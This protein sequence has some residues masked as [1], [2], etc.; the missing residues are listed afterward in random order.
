[1][2]VPDISQVR[3]YKVQNGGNDKE[4]TPKMIFAEHFKVKERYEFSEQ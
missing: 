3:I 2:R 1:M 4:T